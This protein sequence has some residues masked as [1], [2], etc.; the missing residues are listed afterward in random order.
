MS[1]ITTLL[2]LLTVMD[3]DP[4]VK[5]HFSKEID[6]IKFLRSKGEYKEIFRY[7]NMIPHISNGTS[8]QDTVYDTVNVLHKE[9]LVE[10]RELEIL[11]GTN[12]INALLAV[13]QKLVGQQYPIALRESSGN[14]QNVKVEFSH[15]LKDMKVSDHP[16]KKLILFTL[17]QAMAK[18]EELYPEFDVVVH[19]KKHW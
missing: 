13:V 14:I 6:I 9:F 5:E 7:L 18:N 10:Q 3:K 11:K 4:S 15:F 16:H 17:H 1:I 19:N 12:E 2:E 8:I